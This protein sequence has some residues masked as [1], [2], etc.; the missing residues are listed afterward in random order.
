MSSSKLSLDDLW[1]EAEQFGKPW[2]YKNNDGGYVCSIEFN[3]ITHIELKA[4]GHGLV[5]HDALV[6]A[7]EKAKLVIQ[8]MGKETEH[9]RGLLTNA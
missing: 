1:I 5:P 6:Q 8:E 7:I 9:L 4:R 2:L 3:T